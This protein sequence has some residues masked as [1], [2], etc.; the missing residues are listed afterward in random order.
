MSASVY[1]GNTTGSGTIAATMA[2][3]VGK[4]YQVVSVSVTYHIAPV[5]SED[6]AI[7][8]DANAGGTY[9]VRLY[10][11][12]PSAP[13]VT[14]LLWQPDEPLILEGGDAVDVDYPNTDKRTYTVQITM[15]LV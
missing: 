1:K 5:T 15:Q 14:S 9:D 6:L 7:T 13:A 8:L 4:H 11:V 10:T 2:V 12:D 3:P